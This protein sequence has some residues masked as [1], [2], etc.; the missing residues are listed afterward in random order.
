[1]ISMKEITMSWIVKIKPYIWSI[2]YKN[3]YVPSGIDED[4]RNWKIFALQPPP[5]FHTTPTHMCVGPTH[6]WVGVGW[7]LCVYHLLEI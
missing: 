5:N 6:M 1:M 7:E 2:Y 3:W 4:I